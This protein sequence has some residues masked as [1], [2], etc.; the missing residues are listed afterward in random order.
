MDL[1]SLTGFNT[2]INSLQ[3]TF[4]IGVSTEKFSLTTGVGT[5]GAT[6][7]VTFF[8]ISGGSFKNAL[9]GLRENDILGIGSERIRILNVDKENSRVRVLRAVDS[10]V[11][12]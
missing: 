4:N 9:L 8:N 7:I 1:V 12:S 2:S 11:A 5:D 6:G 10:T 3:R